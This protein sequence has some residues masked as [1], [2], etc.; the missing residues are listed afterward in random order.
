MKVEYIDHVAI[1]VKDLK[2][3]ERLFT[4][5][6][7]MKF[8][9]VVESPS[10]DV[11]STIEHN[12]IELVAPYLPDGPTAKALEKRGEG[13]SLLSLK[14]ENLDQAMAE[15][16]SHGIRL[17]SQLTDKS[18]RAALYHPADTFGVMIELDTYDRE[19]PSYTARK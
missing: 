11:I 1:N 5:V 8:C 4:T 2:K 18:F 15:M 14:V 13:L 17:V 9:P 7:G 10:I 16:Q 6:F 3:A 12:G 19:H